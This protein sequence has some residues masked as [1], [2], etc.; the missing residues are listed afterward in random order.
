MV[1]PEAL[2]LVLMSVDSEVSYSLAWG[3]EAEGSHAQMGPL[4]HQCRE[5]AQGFSQ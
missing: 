3:S 4:S 5:G 2:A 1:R